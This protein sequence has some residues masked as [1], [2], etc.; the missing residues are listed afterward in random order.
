MNLKRRC[1]GRKGPCGNDCVAIAT[2]ATS[3]IVIVIYYV[4]PS[5]EKAQKEKV[6]VSRAQSQ[7][8]KGGLISES[9][10]TLVPLSKKGVTLIS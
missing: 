9:I 2:I 10:L 8:T 3:L 7:F 5:V 6:D 1:C 4:S